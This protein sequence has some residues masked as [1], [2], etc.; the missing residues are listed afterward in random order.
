MWAGSQRLAALRSQSCLRWSSVRSGR[1]AAGSCWGWT[2]SGRSGRTRLW[3]S[4]TTVAASMVW[5]NCLVLCLPTWRVEHCS[6]WMES[7]PWNWIPSRAMRRRPSRRRKGSRPPW[8]RTV[9]RQE[10][11]EVGE[12]GG[13]ETVEQIADLVVTRNLADTEEGVAVGVG[14][15]LVHAALEVEE[16]GG[17]EEER[18]EGRRPRHRRRRSACW[19]RY[20]GRAGRRRLVGSGPEGT[21]ALG[22]WKRGTHFMFESGARKV[23]PPETG[24][25]LPAPQRLARQKKAKL[26]TTARKSL[27]ISAFRTARLGLRWIPCVRV[28]GYPRH[29]HRIPLEARRHALARSGRGAGRIG[30]G[31]FRQSGRGAAW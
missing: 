13:V 2:N 21:R 9:S 23:K 25:L 3:P 29:P 10:G 22:H 11:E 28:D 27:A 7:E 14:G 31:S 6:Q 18:G 19:S 17:L 24:P 4:A 30:V 26:R 20:G 8:S 15:L 12:E 1:L 16:G 5:K